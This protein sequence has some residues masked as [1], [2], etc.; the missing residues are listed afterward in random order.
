MV[1]VCF[2]RGVYI[3]LHALFSFCFTVEFDEG[4]VRMPTLS[5]GNISYALDMFI[6]LLLVLQTSVVLAVTQT[7]Q[8]LHPRPLAYLP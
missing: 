3:Y 5:L 1:L 7:Y 6:A 4:I 2:V 8:P